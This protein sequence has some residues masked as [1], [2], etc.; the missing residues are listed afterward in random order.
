MPTWN[1]DQYLRFADERTRACR[2]LAATVSIANARRIID[3]GCGPGNSTAV[4]AARWPD[5]EIV[6]LDSSPDMIAKAR[7]SEPRRTWIAGDI[8]KWM[9]SSREQ[10]DLVFSNAALHW[11]ENHGEALPKLLSRVAPGGAFAMQI[12]GNFDA[13]AHTAMRELAASP[14]WR[15]KFP[16]GPVREWHTHEP[17]FY[18]DTLSSHAARIDL[19]ETTYVHVM[20]NAEAIAEW[21]KGTGLR[22]F[23]DALPSPAD[24]DRFTIGYVEKLR[25]AY[26]ESRDGRRLFPFRRIFL[27]AYAKKHL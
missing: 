2:D 13:P 20:E 4:L 12:P 8:S 24:R 10:F 27:I 26:P 23:L 18:Y 1:A 3:L 9:A 14:E 22:P 6:G 7:E 11:V 19:W 25:A 5:A 15:D 21:Y 16:P 17:D